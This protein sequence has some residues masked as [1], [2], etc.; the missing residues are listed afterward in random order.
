M[1][2]PMVD[3]GVVRVR[4]N[5]WLVPVRVA[6][7]LVRRFGGVVDVLVMFVVGMKMV[8]LHRLMAMLVLVPFRQV[9]PHTSTHENG[10][11]AEADCE[12]V[13]QKQKRDDCAD[14]WRDGKVCAGSG[15]PNVT[16]REHE[17]RQ[18]HAVAD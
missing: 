8:V 12:F 10:G 3:V 1:P 5:H 4:M 13:V 16:E 6:V 9:K 17:Q 18:T 7:R 15:C 2:V 14:E 11:D